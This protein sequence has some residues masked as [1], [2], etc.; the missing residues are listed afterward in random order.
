MEPLT[1]QTIFLLVAQ[2]FTILSS[3]GFTA[4]VFRP[5]LRDVVIRDTTERLLAESVPQSVVQLMHQGAEV[6]RD[7]VD[8]VDAV[9]DGV[10]NTP[11]S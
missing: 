1:Q 8:F 3:V 5:V 7:V 9:T 6:A 4:W 2:L 11:P 10:A